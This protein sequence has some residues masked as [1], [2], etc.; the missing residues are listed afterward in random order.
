MKFL[1]PKFE[2]VLNVRLSSKQM[3]LYRLYLEDVVGNTSADA[4]RARHS[5]FVDYQSLQRIWT[6]PYTLYM[7]QIEAEKRVRF[8]L[9]FVFPI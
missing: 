8:P 5:L 7:Q 2:Y 1:P 3:E 6:H 4:L 9:V